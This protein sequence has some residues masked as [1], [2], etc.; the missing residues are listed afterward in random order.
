MLIRFM[1]LSDR[2]TLRQIRNLGFFRSVFG[3]D[4]LEGVSPLKRPERE[5][6]DCGIECITLAGHLLRE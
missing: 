4:F 6:I 3:H 5:R 1:L 2:R